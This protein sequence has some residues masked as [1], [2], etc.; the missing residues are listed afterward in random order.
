MP[1]LR[2]LRRSAALKIVS[3][4]RPSPSSLSCSAT[5]RHRICS[6]RRPVQARPGCFFLTARFALSKACAPRLAVSLLFLR[7]GLT[8]RSIRLPLEPT[9]SRRNVDLTH[10]KAIDFEIGFAARGRPLRGPTRLECRTG[11]GQVH[12]A[13]RRDLAEAQLP[14]PAV[15]VPDRLMTHRRSG[16]VKR[17][18]NR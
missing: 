10:L 17:T 18:L 11:I 12:Q 5:S 6:E 3:S 8:R 15:P 9:P 4:E 13:D 2:Y 16:S 1:L 14:V 7:D